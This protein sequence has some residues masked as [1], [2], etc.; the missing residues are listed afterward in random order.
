MDELLDSLSQDWVSQPRSPHSE[1][2]RSPIANSPSLSSNTSQSRIPRIKPSLPSRQSAGTE[3]QRRSSLPTA[4]AL[5]EKSSSRLNT[6]NNQRRSTDAGDTSNSKSKARNTQKENELKSPAATPPQDTVQV[7]AS[8]KKSQGA[9]NTPEWK[10]RLKDKGSSGEQQDLFS[11]IG[12]QKL[13]R[14]PTI[15]GKGEN[16]NARRYQ[17]TT[18]HNGSSSPS[19]SIQQLRPIPSARTGTGTG[20]VG[21]DKRYLKTVDEG[22]EADQELM[23]QGGTTLHPKEGVQ[24]ALREQ[25]ILRTGG[26]QPQNHSFNE[27]DTDGAPRA[28]PQIQTREDSAISINVPASERSRVTSGQTVISNEELSPCYVSRQDTVDGRIDYA[29]IADAEQV[30]MR[31][32]EVLQERQRRPTPPSSNGRIS[33]TDQSS[34]APSPRRFLPSSELTSHSL[35]EDLSTGTVEFMANGGFVNARRGGRSQEGS[36]LTR[37]LSPSSGFPQQNVGSSASPTPRRRST[38][39]L[40]RPSVKK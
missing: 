8:P 18:A 35:P 9:R 30:R 15:R 39:S 27:H 17:P 23:S 32:Q 12:L 5:S 11:P 7:R 25:S 33:Y 37:P 20:D 34:P 19:H 13:F 1:A 6:Y 10:R 24:R 26:K 16:N 22:A 14:P 4:R 31:M 36:F 38:G 29:T 40:K 3:G 21:P 28:S 2:R